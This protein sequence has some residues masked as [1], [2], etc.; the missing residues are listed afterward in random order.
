MRELLRRTFRSLRVRNFRIFFVGQFVSSVG[1]W[2]QQ[3]AELWL[4]ADITGSATAVGLITVAHFGPV[5]LF[6]LWGGVIA[7]RLDKRR[8]LLVTQTLLAAIAAGLAIVSATGGVTVGILYGFA[9]ATGLVQALDNPARRAFVREMVDRENVSNAVSLVS[10]VFTSSRIIGPALTGVLLVTTGPTIVFAVNALSYSGVLVALLLMRVTE[11]YSFPPVAKARGQLLEGL[12]Y[13]WG[14]AGVRLPLV[15]MA[16]IGTLAFNFSVL[17]VL[18]A[19]QTFDAGPSGY[20]I[21]LSLSAIGSLSGALVAAARPRIT[22]RFLV[23]A[24]LSYGVVTIIASTAPSLIAMALLLIPVGLFGVSFLSGAQ[25]AMQEA[26]S[27]HMQG[28]VMALFAVVFLGGTPIGGMFAG[29]VSEGWGPRVAFAMGGVVA[30]LTGLW[31]WRA[32]RSHAA[33]PEPAP[34]TSP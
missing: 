4:V 30:L 29:L 12:R 14:T 26:A 16:W 20:G 21:L 22:R 9:A 18:F 8:L 31:A 25:G 34:V 3:V 17:L 15:M 6:G 13:S 24:S 7:D 5:L 28:R 1:L 11:L 19:E 32:G 10:M 27:P 33:V 23:N 2:M